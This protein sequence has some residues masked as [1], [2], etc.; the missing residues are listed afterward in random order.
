MA[1]L[2]RQSRTVL[3]HIPQMLQRAARKVLI[4]PSRAPRKNAQGMASHSKAHTHL[5]G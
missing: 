4:T 3:V 2:E 5:W 1:R